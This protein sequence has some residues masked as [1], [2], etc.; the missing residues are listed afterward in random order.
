MYAQQRHYSEQIQIKPKDKPIDI[1]DMVQK[2][3]EVKSDEKLAG[4]QAEDM[5]LIPEKE[6]SKRSKDSS[7]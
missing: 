7:T 3:K 5:K 2:N 4:K 6:E 1:T